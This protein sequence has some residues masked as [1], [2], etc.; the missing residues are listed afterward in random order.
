MSG[1][2]PPDEDLS[3]FLDG[4]PSPRRAAELERHLAAC[5]RCRSV[6]ADLRAVRA[7]LAGLP[8]AEAREG[9]L[10]DVATTVAG[11]GLPTS[12]LGVRLRR[13]LRVT[14]GLVAAAVAALAVGLWAVP[15]P[16]APVS[17][18]DEVRH[19]LVQIDN[20]LA[21]QTSYVVEVHFP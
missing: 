17:F 20:P 11:G 7:T 14:G 8:E 15:P 6:L 13:R 18:Q 5:E 19:H 9:W 21:D 3:S 1:R 16:P 4:T 12:T 2:H 10:P